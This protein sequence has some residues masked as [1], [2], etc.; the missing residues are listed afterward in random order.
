MSDAKHIPIEFSASFANTKEIAKLIVD[1]LETLHPN[2]N[3]IHLFLKW[4]TDSNADHTVF[5]S[6]FLDGD[7]EEM[8]SIFSQTESISK[9][10]DIK[11]RL[12]KIFPENNDEFIATI[13]GAFVKNQPTEVK[14]FVVGTA[15]MAAAAMEQYDLKNKVL[16]MGVQIS[17]YV[18]KIAEL[19]QQALN[20]SAAFE[21]AKADKDAKI[22]ELEKAVLKLKLYIAEPVIVVGDIVPQTDKEPVFDAKKSYEGLRALVTLQE[23]R[24]QELENCIRTLSLKLHKDPD[25]KALPNLNGL[26]EIAKQD[27]AVREAIIK[28]LKKFSYLVPNSLYR[29]VLLFVGCTFY[30][31]EFNLQALCNEGAVN[32]TTHYIY[33]IDQVLEKLVLTEINKAFETSS[34]KIRMHELI[35]KLQ[36][37]L[38]LKP[39]CVLA[40]TYALAYKKI[41]K[42]VNNGVSVVSSNTVMEIADQEQVNKLLAK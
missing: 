34:S 32:Q 2:Y 33:Y 11:E 37:R 8:W 1:K 12:K 24:L 36:E 23:T 15:S 21:A 16:D 29:E 26:N 42:P 28:A 25:T 39:D 4:L 9:E 13:T 19:E 38:T 27:L 14:Y 18:E 30:E 31:Y 7:F 35:V 3:P 20:N 22:A 17:S 40:Y 6:R 10:L 5:P 41:I